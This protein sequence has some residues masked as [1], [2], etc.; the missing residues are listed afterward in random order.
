[1]LSGGR[2]DLEVTICDENMELVCIGRQ[3]ILVLQAA[4]RFGDSKEK[5]LARL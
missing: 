2:M 5:K 3:T 4:R 1:M